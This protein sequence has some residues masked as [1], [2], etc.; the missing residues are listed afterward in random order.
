MTVQPFKFNLSD[1]VKL[2]TDE[3]I[4]GRITACAHYEH[5]ENQYLVAYSA[6]D[7]RSG[8]D[9]WVESIILPIEPEA[10]EPASSE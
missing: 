3:T 6:T 9:W 4:T 10:K 1:T 5:G 7:G 2:S 8:F